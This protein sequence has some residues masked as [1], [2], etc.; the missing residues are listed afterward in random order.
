MGAKKKYFKGKVGNS[1]ESNRREEKVIGIRNLDTL[2]S[3]GDFAVVRLELDNLV[4]A[5]TTATRYL[6]GRRE[7]LGE[8][9]LEIYY[10]RATRTSSY[11]ARKLVWLY[12]EQRKTG[13]TDAELTSVIEGEKKVLGAEFYNI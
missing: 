8:H 12:Y 2:E 7:V 3:L 11:P 4:M 1:A 13:A 6:E 9:H 10:V 5:E